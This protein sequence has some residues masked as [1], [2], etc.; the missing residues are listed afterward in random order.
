MKAIKLYF[1]PS[2]STLTDLD[3]EGSFRNE[4]FMKGETLTSNVNKTIII[5][6]KWWYAYRSHDTCIID[7]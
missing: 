3:F 6:L 4:F 1:V 5:D 7:I 2:R